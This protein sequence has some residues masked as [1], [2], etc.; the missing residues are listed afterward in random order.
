MSIFAVCP[1]DCTHWVVNRQEL[2]LR[3]DLLKCISFGSLDI[4]FFSKVNSSSLVFHS[5]D[6]GFIGAIGTVFPLSN[7]TLG[8]FFQ[9][10]EEDK[11]PEI[12][13]HFGGHY[14]FLIQ[15]NNYLY[16][17]T[18]GIGT[19]DVFFGSGVQS[20]VSNEL[21]ISAFEEV[22]EQDLDLIE[23]ESSYLNSG[24]STPFKKVQKLMGGIEYLRLN[25][26]GES[27]VLRHQ[28]TYKKRLSQFAL[29]N[30]QDYFNWVDKVFHAIQTSN[31]LFGLNFTGG[32]DGRTILASLLDYHNRVEFYYGQGNSQLTNT[33]IKDLNIAREIAEDLKIP[34]VLMDW[35]TSTSDCDEGSIQTSYALLGSMAKVNG[36]SSAFI[37][38]LIQRN[39]DQRDIVFLGGFSPGFSNKDF[40]ENEYLTFSAIVED[41]L[42]GPLRSV[43]FSE[44]K[45]VYQRFYQECRSFCLA[46]ELINDQDELLI[47][48]H[49]IRALLYIRPESEHLQLYNRFDKYLAPYNTNELLLPML[50]MNKV[51]RAGRKLQLNLINRK[52]PDLLKYHLFSGIT[53]RTI[54]KDLVIETKKEQK[55]SF[56][57]PIPYLAYQYYIF[58]KPIPKKHVGQDLIMYNSIQKDLRENYQKRWF[59]F[60]IF[61]LRY[62]FR[63]RFNYQM[64]S[65][66]RLLKNTI[67]HG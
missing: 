41:C 40:H 13:N 11:L 9:N 22:I 60:S 23:I 37:Q 52:Y 44:Y 55:K 14:V 12:F 3:N 33:Q 65:N 31:L 32:L 59:G 4:H 16:I 8:E 10:F 63:L 62:C 48:G 50:A 35:S 7:L 47:E 28:S 15:K 36:G 21:T 66:Q 34:Q 43:A 24:R 2:A 18:D 64:E 42:N 27:Q 56:K 25:A 17:V 26:H 5:S 20:I 49:I 19:V 61:N 30:D 51:F 58:R 54:A 38:S 45:K 67:Y 6:E 29:W 46:H 1:R 57:I 39:K 53:D